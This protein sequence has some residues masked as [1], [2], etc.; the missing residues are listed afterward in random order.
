M[1]GV[2]EFSKDQMVSLDDPDEAVTAGFEINS[3]KWGEFIGQLKGMGNF[4]VPGM[5]GFDFVVSDAYLDFSTEENVVGVEFPEGYNLNTA[6]DSTQQWRGFFIKEIG[7]TLPE[8]FVLTPGAPR[9][10]FSGKNL[11]IDPQGI[12]TNLSG[13]N[14][15]DGEVD[16]WAF[17][18]DSISVNIMANSLVDSDIAGS[19]GVP[20][21]DD[22]LPFI[23]SLTKD[24]DL[25]KMMLKPA[26]DVD[27]NISALKSA[28]NIGAQT[29]IVVMQV[30]DTTGVTPKKKFLPYADLYGG[31]GVT[32]TND[33][34]NNPLFTGSAVQEAKDQ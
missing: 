3:K 6:P 19:I 22:E 13:K 27:L 8:D 20:M 30:I 10:N 33:D 31:V 28:I 26:G 9:P 23:G 11:L 24:N 29:E 2:Y 12:S 5:E 34:F 16:G 32:V 17:A 7:L 14:I 4:T 21:I 15:M 25:Y 1:E 18:M